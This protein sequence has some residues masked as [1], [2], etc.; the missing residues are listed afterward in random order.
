VVAVSFENV[1]RLKEECLR[2]IQER[3]R[4]LALY[5]TALL[6]HL[7][8]AHQLEKDLSEHTTKEYHRL[9]TTF[10]ELLDFDDLKPEVFQSFR[11]IGNAV[12]F[13]RNLSEVLEI[14]GQSEFMN[15][16]PLLGLVPDSK[17]ADK[18][19]YQKHAPVMKAYK[20]LA[21]AVD[22]RAVKDLPVVAN[23]VFDIVFSANSQ[24][25][26]DAEDTSLFAECMERVKGLFHDLDLYN[27]W[28]PSHSQSAG[29][30][31]ANKENKSFFRLWSALVFLFCV[32]DV[33]SEDDED[34]KE[35][36]VE[37]SNEEEFGHGFAAA[38]ALVLHLLRQKHAF[39]LIDHATHMLKVISGTRAKYS[40]A[41][42]KLDTTDKLDAHMLSEEG[43]DVDDDGNLPDE[44]SHF[45]NNARTLHE[46]HDE[47]FHFLESNVSADKAWGEHEQKGEGDNAAAAPLK[48]FHP[49]RQ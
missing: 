20:R 36:E 32:E 30:L 25:A 31:A 3:L 11:E 17:Q 29:T 21:S 9:L 14:R 48:I 47:Y 42:A 7:P 49:P 24:P 28:A 34:R 13:L 43:L 26:V 45:V 5:V 40:L 46:L 8:V 27:R 38:G 15:L 41:F 6:D 12:M 33:P 1:P 10:G 44:V 2:L 37:I 16:S 18:R 4:K 19:L 39:Q 22:R 23:S 35:S